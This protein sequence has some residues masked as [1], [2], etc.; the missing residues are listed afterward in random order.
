MEISFYYPYLCNIIKSGV[1]ELCEGEYS[2]KHV[3]KVLLAIL[4]LLVTLPCVT[5]S[6]AAT[7]YTGYINKDTYVYQKASKSSKKIKVARN[8]KVFPVGSDVITVADPY[9]AISRTD[10]KAAVV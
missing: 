2:M 9:I 7:H 4:V 1:N 5:N 10:K 3:R 6:L 8:T